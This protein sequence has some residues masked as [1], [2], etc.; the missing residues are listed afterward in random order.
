MNELCSI[1]P[2]ISFI[3]VFSLYKIKLE[4]SALSNELHP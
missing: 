2:N 4:T 1:S 3:S